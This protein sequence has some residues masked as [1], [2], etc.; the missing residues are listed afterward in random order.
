MSRA[1]EAVKSSDYAVPM[2]GEPETIQARSGRR[3]RQATVSDILDATRRLLAAGT[4]VANLSVE[5]IV[6]EAGVARATFYLHFTDKHALIARLAEDEIAWRE[7]I[8]AE[9]LAD[10]HLER[11]ALDAMLYEIVARWSADRPV[12]SA[13]IELAEYDEHVATIWASAMH[14]VAEKAAAQFRARWAHDAGTVD[15]DTIAE[16]FTWMFERSCHQMLT[17][18]A[19]ID[20]VATGMSEIIWRVLDYGPKQ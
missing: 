14:R 12:L 11:P 2:T 7:Q 4:P 1:G 5:R 18:P 3:R 9:V 13:I 20:R 15:P 6:A 10:P 8:G 16:I 19:D 17:D